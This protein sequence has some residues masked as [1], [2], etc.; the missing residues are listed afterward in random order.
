MTETLSRL[1]ALQACDRRLRQA[2]LTLETLQRSLAA[3][4]EEAAS[5]AHDLQARR[6]AISEAEQRRQALVEQLDQIKEQLRDKK[7]ALHRCRPDPAAD[8]A[9]REVTLLETRKAV[10]E[11]ELASVGAQRSQNIE[12]L[13]RTEELVPAQNEERQRAVSALLGHIT[14]TEEAVRIIQDER[15]VLAEGISPF[16]LHEYERIFSHRGGVAVVTVEHETCQGCHLHVPTHICLELQR[17]PRMTLCPNCQRILFV[18]KE[19][20]V[21]PSA[22]HPSFANE[23][24]P[25][26]RP[27]RTKAVARASKTPRTAKASQTTTTAVR[28]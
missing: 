19:T 8:A 27:R 21:A 26:R 23:H 15:A 3:L 9:Q 25:S 28:M 18:P 14:A 13:R 2:A 16:L 11:E 12:A 7:Y 17:H 4:Q 20:P 5:K 22:F 1:L 10:L 24:Q 6:D